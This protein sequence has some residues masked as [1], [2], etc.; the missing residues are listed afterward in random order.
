MGGLKT[1]TAMTIDEAFSMLNG[2]MGSTNLYGY[3]VNCCSHRYK[4]FAKNRVCVSCGKEGTIMKLQYTSGSKFKSAHF[5]LYD[6]EGML[7]TKDHIQPKSHGGINRQSNYQ[8]M[9]LA[10]N[11]A[12]GSLT[13]AEW[14]SSL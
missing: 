12:M 13:Q 10:C 3:S 7:F 6:D 9:C 1:I 8:T 14:D 11:S 5:N 4:L 2:F